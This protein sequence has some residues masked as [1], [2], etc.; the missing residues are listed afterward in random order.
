MNELKQLSAIP[1]LDTIHAALVAAT[2]TPYP[3]PHGGGDFGEA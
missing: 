1:V 2:P 3:S